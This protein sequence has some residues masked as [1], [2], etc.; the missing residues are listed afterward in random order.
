MAADH[1]RGEEYKEVRLW[2]DIQDQLAD[3]AEEKA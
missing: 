2:E 3:C 1:L